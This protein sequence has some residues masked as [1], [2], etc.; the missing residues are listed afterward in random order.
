MAFDSLLDKAQLKEKQALSCFL[1]CLKHDME[2]MV[3]MFNPQNL[4]DA[5]SLAKLQEALKN[6][7]AI[8]GTVNNKRG[9]YR[10]NGR[11]YLNTTIKNLGVPVQNDSGQPVKG[12][13]SGV[14]K[15]RPLNLTPQ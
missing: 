8:S 14:A 6:D 3:R 12:N 7:P 2:M 5:Y 13:L 11:Q 1:A 9:V 4:E 15:R 10:G